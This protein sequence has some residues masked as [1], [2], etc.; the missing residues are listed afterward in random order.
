MINWFKVEFVLLNHLGLQPE[1]LDSMEF[2]RAEYLMENFKDHN[3][4]ENKRNSQQN[5]S[6]TSDSQN[7]MNSQR[8]MMNKYTSRNNLGN[9]KAPKF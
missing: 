8:S 2:Y 3:E 1:G 4:N 7:M 9:F 6:M 5:E